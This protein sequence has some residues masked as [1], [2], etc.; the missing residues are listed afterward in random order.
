MKD[1]NQARNGGPGRRVRPAGPAPCGARRVGVLAVLLAAVLVPLPIPAVESECLQVPLNPF[2]ESDPALAAALVAA[3][4]RN[5]DEAIARL[6][7]LAGA[8]ERDAAQAAALQYLA[9]RILEDA[10]RTGE[11]LDRYRSLARSI[12]SD[13]ALHRE[14]AIRLT[15]GDVTGARAAFAGISPA[16]PDWFEARI[17]LSEALVREG[18]PSLARVVLKDLFRDDLGPADLNRARIALSAVLDASGD[19]DAARQVAVTAYLFAPD[20]EE[21]RTAEKVLARLGAPVTPL[22][23]TVRGLARGDTDD[24]RRIASRARRNRREMESLDP[25]LP[26]T[27]RALS[28]YMVE[29]DAP[30]ACKVLEAATVAAA[31]PLLKSYATHLLGNALATK[32]DDAAARDRQQEIVE[33]WADSPFAAV[34]A[35][36]GARS[37]MRLSDF[38]GALRLLDRVARV[39]PESGLDNR[40]RWEMALVSLV[41]G[42]ADAALVHLDEAVSRLD[43]GRGLLFGLAE[44]VRYFRGVALTKLGR[45]AEG[46]ADIERIA[47]GYPHSYYAVLAM[48]RLAARSS[49][50]VPIAP[51]AAAPPAEPETIVR[52]RLVKVCDHARGPVLLWR[53][54]YTREGI[55]TL[56]ARARLGLLDEDGLV[57]LAALVADGRS[58][59]LA[60][61]AR[62][63]LRGSSATGADDLY[64]TAYPR[65]FAEE[66]SEAATATGADPALVWG[67]MRAES[68][69]NP[70]ARSPVGAVGLMQLMPAT[71]RVVASRILED[72]GPGR[73]VWNPRDNVLVGSAFLAEL[74][75]HFRGHLPLVL[76][77]YNA[78]PG[79][80]RRFYR[81]MKDLPT[82]LFVEAVPYPATV[83]Y[84]KKVVGFSAG[85]R[86]LFDAAGRGPLLVPDTL[87]ESLG[88][89]MER[90]KTEPR[91]SG[92]MP[93]L[94]RDEPGGS[95]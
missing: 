78:G 56:K 24:V 13:Q 47:R 16:S 50:P 33:R 57:V 9:G 59:K 91:L 82:D 44:K 87:P 3:R 22:Q 93:V 77:A 74:G 1:C 66:V 36:N 75:R 10:G 88:P 19:V 52:G 40:A 69:F 81:R 30:R 12:L 94:A 64:Q 49:L 95:P 61:G 8:T 6:D 63:Y 20:G 54:G 60:A 42:R 80:A 2:A 5:P 85:Y 25:G 34:A 4:K 71:A 37:R 27:I 46:F 84:V 32:G 26:D 35:I 43:R 38:E 83:A 21:V 72:P 28:A 67:V 65:P 62:E 41:A 55:E 14:G 45:T 76:I 53:L 89:F 51:P 15:R 73:R 7:A 39:Y 18:R 29:K 58:P 70:K 86:G 79:A 90:R 11:A 17:A 48:S 92:A 31:D 23:R 68:G